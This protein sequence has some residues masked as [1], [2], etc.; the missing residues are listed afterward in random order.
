MILYVH[1]LSSMSLSYSLWSHLMFEISLSLSSYPSYLSVAHVFYNFLFFFSVVVPS[2][3]CNALADLRI[4]SMISCQKR[5]CAP[6]RETT[7]S[8]SCGSAKPTLTPAFVSVAF[9]FPVKDITTRSMCVV[10]YLLFSVFIFGFFFFFRFFSNAFYKK[11]KKKKNTSS[12]P[13]T[14]VILTS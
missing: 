8:M 13:L 11:K 2:P 7:V 4:A 9:R 10:L 12:Q 6:L 1:D 3:K 14:V 5:P